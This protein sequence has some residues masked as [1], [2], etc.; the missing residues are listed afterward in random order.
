MVT[1]FKVERWSDSADLKQFEEINRNLFPVTYSLDSFDREGSFFLI[2]LDETPIGA[3]SL[4]GGDQTT[5]IYTFGILP[6]FRC[7][8]LGSEVWVLL[9]KYISEIFFSK[10][11][12]LHVN[13][14]NMKAIKFYK[15]HGF[16]IKSTIENY[17][18]DLPCNSTYF[19]EKNISSQYPPFC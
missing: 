7:L 3:F 8:G 14:T 15:K 11:I 4:K 6:S 17:Y 19:L 1:F 16:V 12:S 10:T 9:E 5:Y 2:Q 13:C 18:E